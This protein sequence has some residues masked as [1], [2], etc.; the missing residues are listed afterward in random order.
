MAMEGSQEVQSLLASDDSPVG[1][2][3][4]EENSS[5]TSARSKRRS[6]AEMAAAKREELAKLNAKDVGKMKD[7]Q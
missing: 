4:H 2:N 3:I 5:V 6:A 7:S 1:D